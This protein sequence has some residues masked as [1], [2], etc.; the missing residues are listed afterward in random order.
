MLDD[1]V[2]AGAEAATCAEGPGEGADYHVDF[3]RVDVLVLG[4]TAA[5]AAQDAEGPCFIEDEA[6]FV[7]EL[8][9][10]L[11]IVS[12]GTCFHKMR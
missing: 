5:G 12:T 10:D 11:C 4:D 7:A 1:L 3:G 6:E 9:F 2:G 8:E